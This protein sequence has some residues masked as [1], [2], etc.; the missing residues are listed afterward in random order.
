MA[1]FSVKEIVDKDEFHADL[2][3]LRAIVIKYSNNEIPQPLEAG[4]FKTTLLKLLRDIY[5]LETNIEL[6]QIL[7]NEFSNTSSIPNESR[8]EGIAPLK[9]LKNQ[10]KD[11]TN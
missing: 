3:N 2:N 7:L 9:K 11:K 8:D 1:F 5:G 10:T 4:L 6:A